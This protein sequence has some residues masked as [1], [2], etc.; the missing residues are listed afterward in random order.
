MLSQLDLRQMQ[1]IMCPYR[2]SNRGCTQHFASDTYHMLTRVSNLSD[3]DPD[4]QTVRS[5]LIGGFCGKGEVGLVEASA[6]EF[7]SEERQRNDLPK[8][9]SASGCPASW[10]SCSTGQ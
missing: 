3:H 5:Q 1:R 4:L 2:Q 6:Q 10:K 8:G 9:L 7:V